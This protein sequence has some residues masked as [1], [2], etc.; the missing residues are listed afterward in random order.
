[1]ENNE[2]VEEFEIQV[3]DHLERDVDDECSHCGQ[4]F[5]PDEVVIERIIYGKKREF[6]SEE[7]LRE[8]QEAT[9]FKDEDLDE[10]DAVPPSSDD[11]YVGEKEEDDY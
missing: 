2:P 3:K 4:I 8:F 5:V 11:A 1:M 6:C 9:N 7:C 10:K